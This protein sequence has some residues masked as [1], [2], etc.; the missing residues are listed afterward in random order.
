MA[1]KGTLLLAFLERLL[2]SKI[3]T[4]NN[5]IIPHSVSNK[6]LEKEKKPLYQKKGF[7]LCEKVINGFYS[8]KT[9][10]QLLFYPNLSIEKISVKNLF[11]FFEKFFKPLFLK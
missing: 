10:W 3:Q 4:W 1:T 7:S 9:L 8:M 6:S 5:Y 2:H 11:L